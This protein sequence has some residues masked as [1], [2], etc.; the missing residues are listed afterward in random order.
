MG[1]RGGGGRGG[2]GGGG[3]ASDEE[4]L[5]AFRREAS[6]LETDALD[7]LEDGAELRVEQWYNRTERSWVTQLT[8]SSGAQVG[9]A[10]YD[11]GAKRFSEASRVQYERALERAR[12]ALR[13]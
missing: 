11:G 1:G 6:G 12:S 9:T 5:R 10:A 3:A 8:D 13:G 7:A 2:G 4:R